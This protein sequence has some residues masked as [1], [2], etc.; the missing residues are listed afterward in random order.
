M[1]PKVGKMK[2]HLAF[3]ATTMALLLILSTSSVSAG[4]DGIDVQENPDGSFS[5][6]GDFITLGYNGDQAPTFESIGVS[7]NAVSP[8]YEPLFES[9][10]VQNFS[11]TSDPSV[12]DEVVHVD[13]SDLEIEFH[14]NPMA[15]VFFEASA[16]SLVIFSFEEEIGAIVNTGHA[17]LGKGGTTGELIALG[18]ATLEKSFDQIRLRMDPGGKCIYRGSIV[19]NEY[20]GERIS[21]GAVAGELYLTQIES[22]VVVDLIQYEAVTISPSFVSAEKTVVD[23]SGEFPTGKAIILT[24]DRSMFTVSPEDLTV[25]LDDAA[26]QMIDERDTFFAT[27]EASFFVSYNENTLEA[28]VYIPHF[29][30]HRVVLTGALPSEFPLSTLVVA[31]GGAMVVLVATAYLFKR[32]A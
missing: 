29:S 20:I 18:D 31:L 19:P 28:L 16:D 12:V 9:V 3:A 23:V 32:R 25:K 10:D 22:N 14:N 2:T 1:E 11:P 21:G 26:I 5:I 17:R 30:E 27:T 24:I 13:S 7:K 8:F 4:P 6:T 15:S